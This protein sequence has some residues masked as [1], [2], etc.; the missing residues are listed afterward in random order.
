MGYIEDSLV[1]GEEVLYKAHISLLGFVLPAI[2]LVALWY[3]TTQMDQ[4]FII[5][6]VLVSIYVLVRI[7]FTI[8]STEFALTNKRI[9]AK[10]GFIRRNSIEIMLSKLESISVI[11]SVDGRIFRFGTVIVVGS[12]GTNQAFKMIDNPM[13]L[14]KRVNAQISSAE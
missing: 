8:L 7:I 14:R 4:A 3:I 6:M 12:G 10:T 2:L 13:E 11:Q 5:V 9:V 1:P